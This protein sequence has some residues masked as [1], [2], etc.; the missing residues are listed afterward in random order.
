MRLGAKELLLAA[1]ILALLAVGLCRLMAPA[2]PPMRAVSVEGLQ[3]P[4]EIVG[5]GQIVTRE[6]HWSPPDD[7]YLIGWHPLVGAPQ[8]EPELMLRVGEVRIFETRGWAPA[9]SFPAG[10]G[11]LVRKGQSV[12]LRF[13]LANED[14]ARQSGGARA[15]LY[16]VPVAGN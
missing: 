15:L 1:G 12:T 2:R 14:P 16:F 11:F 3:V 9:A 6:V 5:Q 8:A 13:T 10:S 7:V 4:S